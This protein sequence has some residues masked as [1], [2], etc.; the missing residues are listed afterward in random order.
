MLNF[1]AF[2]FSGPTDICDEF[3]DFIL[4]QIWTNN[5]TKTKEPKIMPFKG[6]D[7]TKV[8]FKPDLAKFKMESLDQDIVGLM[9]RR[10]Y[11]IS[12]CLR[13]VKVILNGKRLPV[14]SPC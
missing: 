4:L 9:S 12:G 8:M 5:M 13:G 2:Y 1:G 11:D 10:A 6:D 3:A 14:C 7:Y